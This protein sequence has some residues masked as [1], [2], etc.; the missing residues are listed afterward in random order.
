MGGMIAVVALALLMVPVFFSVQRVLAGDRTV[1][2]LR[3]GGLRT[4]GAGTGAGRIK[5]P[6]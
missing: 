6:P 5:R 2:R 4:A 1:A 3:A